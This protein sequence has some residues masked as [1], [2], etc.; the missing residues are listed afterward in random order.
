MTSAGAYDAPVPITDPASLR[1]LDA[2][3]NRA[4]EGLRVLEDTARFALDLHDLTEEAKA[5]RHGVRTLLTQAGVDALALIANR[6]T[7]S[8]VGTSI[9]TLAEASRTSRRMIVDAAAGRA[10]EALRSIE[11]TLKLGDAGAAKEAE[12]I[13]YRV[14]ELHKRLSLALGAD[15][16]GFTGWSLCVL[17]TESIC[18]RPWLE[19]AQRAIAGGADCIQLREKTLSDTE[20]LRRATSLVDI[21][22][23]AGASV[24]INDRP[25]IALLAGAD[26][27]HVGQG[28]LP[29][30]AIRK[31]AGS[32]LLVG[33]SCTAIEHAKQ[34]RLDGADNCGVG[35]MFPTTTKHKDA[36]AGPSLLAEYL[37]HD[38]A[39]P[40]ALAIGGI[41][42]QNISE[43]TE[44]ASGRRFGVAVSSAI[45]GADDP[46]AASRSI[47]Q[48]LDT[49]A[50]EPTCQLNSSKP[51]STT[52]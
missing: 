10:A 39:F 36:I 27:V 14:Y 41:D 23:G 28:D 6:D 15:R 35:A 8:D 9:T 24:V 25:D 13:R 47:R 22:L 38:P 48:A 29:V 37:A 12:A 52:A 49:Y 42:A 17:I 30:E 51:P 46:E 20:L 21:A 5:L 11:E 33:V 45:C 3:A 16:A 1:L 31:T 26:G 32:R 7:P 44:A 34:A 50:P 2:A 18:A 43:L 4:S 40:P 19:V